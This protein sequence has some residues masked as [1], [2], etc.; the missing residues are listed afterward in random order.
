MLTILSILLI[1]VFAGLTYFNNKSNSEKKCNKNRYCIDKGAY[2][3]SI[4]FFEEIDDLR[5]SD[6]NNKLLQL[7][8]IYLKTITNI[9]KSLNSKNL[10]LMKK[11]L[12]ILK[13]RQQIKNLTLIPKNL[14]TL[15]QRE[16]IFN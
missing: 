11:K 5:M 8:N 9:T 13:L 15:I 2:S 3:H 10:I 12:F 16:I 1:V 6:D 4:A 14:Y 7:P